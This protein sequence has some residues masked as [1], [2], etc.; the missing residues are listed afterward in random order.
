VF[1]RTKFKWKNLVLAFQ[2]QF[3]RR[4]N[5]FYLIQ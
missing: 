3:V 2:D 5:E 1:L 4:N